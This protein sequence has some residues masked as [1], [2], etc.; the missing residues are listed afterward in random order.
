M[1]ISV[2]KK[3]FC[4]IKEL[5]HGSEYADGDQHT[6]SSVLDED[7]NDL[8]EDLEPGMHLEVGKMEA[9]NAESAG[10]QFPEQEHGEPMGTEH[11][12]ERN[13]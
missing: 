8:E 2:T 1:E 12:G 3:S 6:H 11:L 4:K 5:H 10:I 9:G 7:E 13:K